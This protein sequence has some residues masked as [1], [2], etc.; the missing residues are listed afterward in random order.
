M[1]MMEV[2]FSIKK[3]LNEVALKD[4]KTDLKL[5]PSVVHV[6][7]D[8]IAGHMCITYEGEIGTLDEIK[9]AMSPEVFQI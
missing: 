4:I 5:I 2:C 6:Q 7:I 9:M 3:D 1:N 8:P